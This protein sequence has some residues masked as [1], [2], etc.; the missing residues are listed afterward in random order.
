MMMMM[1]KMRRGSMV[2]DEISEKLCFFS[3]VFGALIDIVTD[4]S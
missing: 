3:L 2:V 1:M 4:I